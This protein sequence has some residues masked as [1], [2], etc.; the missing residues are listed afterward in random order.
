MYIHNFSPT[1]REVISMWG[2][3]RRG[4]HL[5]VAVPPEVKRQ[6]IRRKALGEGGIGRQIVEALE[7]RWATAPLPGRAA[8]P[9]TPL[10]VGGYRGREPV[11][12]GPAVV[13]NPAA[14]NT[15]TSGRY[16]G[17]KVQVQRTGGQSGGPDGVDPNAAPLV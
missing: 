2:K 6:L 7:Q 1:A 10:P 16:A 3:Y 12:G 15:I 11:R 9:G 17:M 4:L 14:S 8:G 5:S 13:P